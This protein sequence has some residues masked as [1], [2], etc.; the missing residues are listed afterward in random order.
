[1]KRCSA[2]A[3]ALLLLGL[4]A[5]WHSQPASGQ[6]DAGWVTLFDGS[7]LNDWNQIGDAN[8][9]IVDGVVQA[10]KG[11]GSGRNARCYGADAEVGHHR[12]VGESPGVPREKDRGDVRRHRDGQQARNDRG[13][14]DPA[15]HRIAGLPTGGHPP[16]GNP[17]RDSTETVGHQDRR[18]GE[19]GSE[20][21]LDTGSI[22][23]FAKSKT[24]AA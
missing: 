18:N 6:A 10:D 12:V 8:W 22:H 20:V 16:G 4:T 11:N 2:I 23:R 3:A 15:G 1:M 14:I 21:A 19:D 17:S 24:C 7:N 9:K 13:W 5:F